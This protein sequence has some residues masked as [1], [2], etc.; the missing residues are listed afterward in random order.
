VWLFEDV[1]ANGLPDPAARM[2]MGMTVPVRSADMTEYVYDFDLT[3]F[4]YENLPEAHVAIAISPN[5]L[6]NGPEV[7]DQWYLYPQKLQFGPGWLADMGWVFRLDPMPLTADMPLTVG[8]EGE[9]LVTCGSGA[10]ADTCCDGVCSPGCALEVPTA[11][12]CDGPEDCGTGSLCCGNAEQ[13]QTQC[14]MAT[15]C[16]VYTCHTSADCTNAPNRCG[17]LGTTTVGFCQ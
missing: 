6:S 12:S 1:G 3:G 8:N 13:T 14:M 16:P 9:G 11:F 4:F 10:C 2:V 17:E 7:G 5:D 15:S